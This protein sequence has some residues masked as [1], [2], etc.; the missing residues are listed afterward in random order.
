[1][2]EPSGV[3]YMS[4]AEVHINV[5]MQDDP[6]NAEDLKSVLQIIWMPWDSNK[7]VEEWKLYNLGLLSNMIRLA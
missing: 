4:K 6:R 7:F 2:K 3:G 5:G 1:M